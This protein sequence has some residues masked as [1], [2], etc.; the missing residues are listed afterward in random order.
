M[1]SQD[2]W[3]GNTSCPVVPHQYRNFFFTRSNYIYIVTSSIILCEAIFCI[4]C[5]NICRCFLRDIIGGTMLFCAV[6]GHRLKVC[7]SPDTLREI[8]ES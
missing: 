4:G 3:V 6:I 5:L 8:L 7:G 2:Y 1:K